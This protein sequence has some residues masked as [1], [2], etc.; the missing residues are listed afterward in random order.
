MMLTGK[1]EKGINAVSEVCEYKAD[2]PSDLSV[3]IY[4]FRQPSREWFNGPAPGCSIVPSG[5]NAA[6]A[7]TSE[8]KETFASIVKTLEKLLSK[9][10]KGSGA[11]PMGSKGA[12]P[13]T[14]YDD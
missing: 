10:T 9:A 14:A 1:S 2:C 4:L 13:D 5:A 7:V 3:Q 11:G 12:E 6:S 8:H